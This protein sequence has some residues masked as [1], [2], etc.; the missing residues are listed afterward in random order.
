MRGTSKVAI[1]LI[2]VVAA[3]AVASYFAFCGGSSSTAPRPVSGVMG[4][5]P[6][7][8]VAPPP[9]MPGQPRAFDAFR[10]SHKFTFQLSRLAGNIGRLDK[11]TKFSLEPDQAR[12]ILAVLTPLRKQTTLDQDQARS[13]IKELQKILTDDQRSAIS[14]MA[15]EH[16]FRREGG[17]PGGSPPGPRPSFDLKAMENFNPFNPP[18]DSP[19]YERSKKRW[20]DLFAAL[21]KKA[22]GK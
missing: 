2:V 3:A 22:K 18:K 10:E 5:G 1:I 8:G 20:D 19:M 17:G 13:A 4:G 9:G 15:P 12:A 14:S 7:A 11:E 6:P 21:E 16:R